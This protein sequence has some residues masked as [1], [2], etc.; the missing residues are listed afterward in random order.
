MEVCLFDCLPDF[1]SKPEGF[2][3]VITVPGI[4]PGDNVVDA[5]D[6][7]EENNWPEDF[8]QIAFTEEEYIFNFDVSE[9]KS[10]QREID[11]S[12]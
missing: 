3:F 5:S 6:L 8:G 4:K 7:A 12:D 2:Y 10:Y 11:S 9:F 1:G